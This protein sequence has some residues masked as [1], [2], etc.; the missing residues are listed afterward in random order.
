VGRWT[1]GLLGDAFHIFQATRIYRH[2]ISDPSQK[3]SHIPSLVSSHNGVPVLLERVFHH[4]WIGVIFCRHELYGS[5]DDVRILLLAS[6]QH[7]PKVVPGHSH[8]NI[9]DRSNVRWYGRMHLV[10]VLQIL[11]LLVS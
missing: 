4:G 3:A 2:G 7:V 11:G 10:L 8:H 5:R 9:S 6:A 1:D